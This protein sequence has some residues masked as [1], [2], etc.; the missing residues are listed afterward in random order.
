MIDEW[1][2]AFDENVENVIQFIGIWRVIE[3]MLIENTFWGKLKCI[4]VELFKS[5]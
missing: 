3:W 5:I 2:W 4:K 1:K